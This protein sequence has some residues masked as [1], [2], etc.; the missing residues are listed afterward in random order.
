LLLSDQNV[1]PRDRREILRAW[2]ET[3]LAAFADLEEL[4][5]VRLEDLERRRCCGERAVELR[6]DDVDVLRR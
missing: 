4:A 3:R 5:Q 6:C 2:T 1:A